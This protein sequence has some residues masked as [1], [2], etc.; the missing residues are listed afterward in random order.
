MAKIVYKRNKEGN[1]YAGSQTIQSSNDIPTAQSQAA[2]TAPVGYE[3]VDTTT[4][5]DAFSKFQAAQRRAASMAVHPAGKSLEDAVELRQYRVTYLKQNGQEGTIIYTARDGETQAD[6]TKDLAELGNTVTSFQEKLNYQQV[7]QLLKQAQ[8]SAPVPSITTSQFIL[9]MYKNDTFPESQTLEDL[10]EMLPYYRVKDTVYS[11][12]GKAQVV[13]NS[14]RNA[15]AII[16]NDPTTG[17][18]K[19]TLEVDAD[20][21]SGVA[22]PHKDLTNVEEAAEIFTTI[23]ED[24]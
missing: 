15:R 24:L 6:I 23:D 12:A 1:R 13:E 10:K 22:Y 5:N 8:H 20:T 4:V 9:E 18:P 21:D 16:Y 2:V 17:E 19:I 14:A 7:R 3:E 11:G